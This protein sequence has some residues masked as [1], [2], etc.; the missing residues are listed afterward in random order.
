MQALVWDFKGCF[1]KVFFFVVTENYSGNDV[2]H[3]K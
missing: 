3:G 2:V 1:N